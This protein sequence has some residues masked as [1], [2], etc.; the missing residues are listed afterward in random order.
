MLSA[1]NSG[2]GRAEEDSRLEIHPRYVFGVRN[3]RNLT[4]ERTKLVHIALDHPN[5][6]LGK[7]VKHLCVSAACGRT[8]NRVWACVRE[9]K[10]RATWQTYV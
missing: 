4:Q 7:F 1:H 3:L 6:K 8:R 5:L 10:E 9:S 2:V